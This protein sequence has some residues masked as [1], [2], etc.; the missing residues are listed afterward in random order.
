M[1]LAEQ[2]DELWDLYHECMEAL[3]QA[4]ANIDEAMEK[5]RE[6]RIELDRRYR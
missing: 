3:D 5:A 1:N 4:K 6:M 2:I